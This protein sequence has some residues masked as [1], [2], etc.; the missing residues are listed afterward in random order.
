[1][2][3]RSLMAGLILGLITLAGVGLGFGQAPAGGPLPF[4]PQKVATVQ[5]VVVAPPVDKPTGLPEMV[6]LTL[7]TS[8]GKNLVVVLGPNWFVAQ[9]SWRIKALD[10]LE[11]KGS[12][13]QLEGKPAL[14]AQEVKRGDEVMTFR[15]EG[16]APLWAGPRGK[17]R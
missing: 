8:Q 16:G 15:D 3:K 4:D 11:V 5:G 6:Q 9:Q 7:K 13:L 10:R 12:P 17:G 2:R 1:M 14:V